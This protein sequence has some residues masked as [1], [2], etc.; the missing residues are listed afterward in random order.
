M[1]IRSG[2]APATMQEFNRQM[3]ALPPGERTRD[4]EYRAASAGYFTAM[5]IQLIRG[6]L[7]QEGDGPDSPHV[8]S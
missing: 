8:A 6:R 3:D 5:G 4:A 2:Q 1:E 7:F